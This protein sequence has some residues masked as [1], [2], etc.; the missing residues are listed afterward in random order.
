MIINTKLTV[1]FAKINVHK[2]NQ[3][4]LNKNQVQKVKLI[5]ISVKRTFINIKADAQ[6]KYAYSVYLFYVRKRE[7]LGSAFEHGCGKSG[8]KHQRRKSSI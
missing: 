5:D 8:G 7:S 3:R 2:I 1:F 4:Y 6:I